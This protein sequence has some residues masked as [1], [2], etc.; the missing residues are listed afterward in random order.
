MAV[1]IAIVAVIV[2]LITFTLSWILF[3]YFHGP[4]PGYDVLL[5]PANLSL[6]YLWH[7]LFT[8]EVNLLP[9]LGLMMI[10]QFVCVYS[11]VEVILRI[12]RLIT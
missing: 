1:K 4:I 6:V 9:K 8:E 7:P 3:D 2:G 12:R 11:F 5:F 10:G